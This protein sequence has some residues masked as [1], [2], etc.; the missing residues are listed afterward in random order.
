MGQPAPTSPTTTPEGGAFTWQGVGAV[1]C[2]YPAV[3]GLTVFITGHITGGP[4]NNYPNIFQSGPTV[5]CSSQDGQTT[6]CEGIAPYSWNAPNPCPA[7]GTTWQ[8]TLYTEMSWYRD[9]V[10]QSPDPVSEP[11]YEAVI[12]CY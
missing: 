5:D 12:T 3:I 7:P 8:V 10:R 1:D 4:S 2:S 11:P 9:G 6:D